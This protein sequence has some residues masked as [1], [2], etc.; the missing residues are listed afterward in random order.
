MRHTDRTPHLL[1][2]TL[3]SSIY[4]R[5][6]RLRAMRPFVSFITFFSFFLAAALV[7]ARTEIISSQDEQIKYG[8]EWRQVSPLVTWVARSILIFDPPR[9]NFLEVNSPISD[10]VLVAR[11]WRCSVSIGASHQWRE[12]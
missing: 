10:G 12:C 1:V 8:G 3:D 9:L 2:R 4:R 6:L 11:L 5:F 7:A